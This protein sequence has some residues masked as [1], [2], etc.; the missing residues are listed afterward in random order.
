[1][2]SRALGA[3]SRSAGGPTRPFR[4]SAQKFSRTAVRILQDPAGRRARLLH[5]PALG[6]WSRSAGGPTRPFRASAQKFSRTAV[7]ILQDPARLPSLWAGN[8]RPPRRRVLA[9]SGRS[10]R[11]PRQT[12]RAIPCAC[13]TSPPNALRFP[14]SRKNSAPGG[15]TVS[16][17]VRC[18]RPFP[19]KALPFPGAQATKALRTGSPGAALQRRNRPVTLRGSRAICSGVPT[20]TMRPPSSPPPG[21]MSIT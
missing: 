2:H 10:V 16:G 5:S 8:G 4:A 17:A 3:W 19:A 7:R 14:L 6:L 1:M 15:L 9:F 12:R 21:P 20:A 13:R 11:M 18:S